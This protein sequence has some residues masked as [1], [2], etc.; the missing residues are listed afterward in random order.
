MN[1]KA[2]SGRRLN[3]IDIAKGISMV[4]IILGHLGNPSINRVVFTFHVPIFFLITGFF[5][6]EKTTLKEFIKIKARTLLLPYFI[7]C[8]VIIVL[9]TVKGF[10]TGDAL[11]AFKTWLYASFYGAGDSYSEPFYI[12]GIGAI[13]F[14]WATFWASC[15]LKIS[16]K[17]KPPTRL[18]WVILLF[19]LGY[20]SRNICWFPFS[21]QAGACA[22]LFM[23]TGYL[24]KKCKPALAGLPAELKLSASVFALITT[25]FFIRDFKS[26][27]LVHC[28]VGRG[29]VDIFGSL[30]ACWIVILI[31]RFI[32]ARTHFPNRFFSYFGRHSL[33]LLCVHIVELDLFPWWSLANRLMRPGLPD[34]FPL[35]LVI[36]GKLTA[37]LTVTFLLE[38]TWGRLQGGRL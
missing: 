16:L 15:F 34:F 17:M 24:A 26:F 38:R 9:G 21:I 29:I 31:S 35:L 20:Y 28:D 19:L 6:N 2:T 1:D 13:W 27:W 36:A 7:T 5:I 12:K 18:L 30:C 22:V 33:L 8:A 37:D 10:L 32:D 25:V 11:S 23:Y 4:C 3:Y 14:L